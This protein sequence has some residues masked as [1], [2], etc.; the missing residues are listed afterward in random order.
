MNPSSLLSPHEAIKLALLAGE[1]LLSNGSETNRVE[2]TMRRVLASAGYSNAEAFVVS[3]GVF[4]SVRAE[5]GDITSVKRITKR[6]YDVQKLI[7]VNDVS[8]SF[9]ENRITPGEAMSKLE[10]IR[11]GTSGY[12]YSFVKLFAAGIACGCF[13]YLFG[14]SFMDCLNAFFTGFILEVLLFQLRKGRV[15]DVLVNILGG[16]MIAFL[17]LT[18]LNLGVGTNLDF[19][20]IGSLMP[21]VPGLTLTNAVRDVLEGDYLSGSARLMD[22]VLVA[23]SVACGVGT[24]IKLWYHIFG[25]VFI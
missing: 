20:I 1:L 3:T 4:V 23:I 7:K 13:A 15:A 2:D 5:A 24:T 25:G 18:I 9:A 12:A 14:G 8:R 22:A 21:L 19:I 11:S 16:I 6:S 17:S 10:E